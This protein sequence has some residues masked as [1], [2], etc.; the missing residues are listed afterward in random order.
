MSQL[1]KKGCPTRYMIVPRAKTIRLIGLAHKL[2]CEKI[3]S[4]LIHDSSQ[5]EPKLIG[6]SWDETMYD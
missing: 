5:N 3:V 6:L 2:A 1:V 4:N